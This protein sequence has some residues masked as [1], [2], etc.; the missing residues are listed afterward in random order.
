VRMTE[1]EHLID[2]AT[3]AAQLEVKV[4][5]VRRLVSERRIPYIK[6][7]RLLRFDPTEVEHWLDRSRVDELVG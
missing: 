2:I 4:R 1:V 7:G 6:L 5:Y 3:V